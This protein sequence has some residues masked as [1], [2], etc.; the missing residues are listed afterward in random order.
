MATPTGPIRCRREAF[1][2]FARQ[3][4]RLQT[5]DALLRAAV[6]ISMH[7]L[8]QADPLVCDRQIQE[9]ADLVRS[10]VHS[11]D[12]RA[13]IAH[14]HDVMFDELG[15][16]GN[17]DDYYHP[18]NSYVPI[19]LQTR[20]G[21]P[22]TLSLIYREL[23]RRLGL[24]VHGV[25]TPGHFIA[26]VAD[27]GGGLL[28]VDAFARGRMLVPDEIYQMVEQMAG[29]P[30]PRT[31]DVMPLALPGQWLRRIIRNLES[32]FRRDNRAA[33]LAAMRDLA[34]LLDQLNR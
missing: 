24:V 11:G 28:Y 16:S 9:W 33:D 21:N 19:V 3:L 18:H 25:N 1:E 5:G 22:I 20:R 30:V 2:M 13:L 7:E 10:R 34:G 8:E 29:A 26:A 6:A 27:P 23:M 4:P 14:A 31:E 12:Y 15:F 32:I 17:V